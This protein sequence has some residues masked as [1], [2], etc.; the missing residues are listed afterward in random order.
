MSDSAYAAH[1]R[2]HIADV[3]I[4]VRRADVH[5]VDRA[6]VV[7]ERDVVDDV[8]RGIRLDVHL[9]LQLRH[10]KAVALRDDRRRRKTR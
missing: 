9:H 10:G 4:V 1:R 7:L 8:H 2:A 3:V 6:A 5:D